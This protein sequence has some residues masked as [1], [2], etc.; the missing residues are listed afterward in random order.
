MACML[1]RK[2]KMKCEGKDKAP[3][4]RCRA[5]G[6]ECTFEAA[7]PAPPGARKGGAASR[8]WIES[9]MSGVEGRLKRLETQRT[10]PSASSSTTDP[11][12]PVVTPSTDAL[13]A[14]I[15]QLEAQVY[16]LTMAAAS[17]TT[18]I[19]S[20]PQPPY[21]QPQPPPLQQ[22]YAQG[23]PPSFAPL[24]PG[25]S[26]SLGAPAHHTN[27]NNTYP[28]QQPSPA[29]TRLPNSIIKK[30]RRSDQ[31]STAPLPFPVRMARRSTLHI[32]WNRVCSRDGAR[33]RRREQIVERGIGMTRGEESSAGVRRLGLRGRGMSWTEG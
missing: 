5:A 4:R 28:H 22:H 9:R 3:C 30:R 19:P 33:R 13:E 14:R 1:C 7:A 20:A 12:S 6:V 31:T 25:R 26:Y 21:T 17:N 8:E 15:A 16:A 27:S 2:Q 32:R 29:S 18:P 24:P 10:S 23:F 11:S